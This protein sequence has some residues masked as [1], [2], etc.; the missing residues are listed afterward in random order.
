MP[1]GRESQLFPGSVKIFVHKPIPTKGR[2]R[3][4]DGV[5]AEARA[6]IAASLPAELVGS[7]TNML[8][9]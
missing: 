1:S 8:E 5:A 2:E 7:A 9:D 3:D 4:A 6:A